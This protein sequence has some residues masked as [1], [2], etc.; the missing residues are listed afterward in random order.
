MSDPIDTGFIHDFSRLNVLRQ[1]AIDGDRSGDALRVVAEQFESLFTHILFKSMR[2]ANEV[3]KSDMIDNR[4]SQ[5][6]QEMADEQMSSVFAREGALG[7]AELIIQ[8]VKGLDSTKQMEGSVNL[9]RGR[10]NVLPTM[11]AVAIRP[12]EDEANTVAVELATAV[13]PSSH[14]RVRQNVEPLKIDVKG[15]KS[16]EEFVSQLTLYANRAA[17]ALGTDPAMLIAQAALETGWGKKIISNVRGNSR[18]LFN[19]KADPKWTGQKIVTQTLEFDGDIPV[20]QI[21]SFRA[22]ASYQDSF[23]DYVYFLKAN[24]R[25]DTALQQSMEPDQFIRGLHQAG[26]STDPHYPDKVISVFSRVKD[27]MGN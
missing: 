23:N 25:Y 3:F 11:S 2:E 18:N 12:L 21:A 17:R 16:P 24:P 7:L 1:K 4:T 5:F 22:Y 15:F 26:Y 13:T 9:L 20:Q 19:I 8:Q 14:M 10:M 27:L 6:Y